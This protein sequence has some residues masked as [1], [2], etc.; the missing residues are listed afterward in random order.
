MEKIIE[1]F[2]PLVPNIEGIFDEILGL[3]AFD[4]IAIREAGGVDKAFFAEKLRARWN[5]KIYL[6]IS[7]SDR[8]RTAIRSELLT[9]AALGFS[10]VLLT[11]G[12][13]PITT[14]FP[15]AKAV[16]DLDA[17]SVLHMLKHDSAAFMG[18]APPVHEF[19][20]W[21]AGF[22]IGG[23][24][25]PDMMRAERSLAMGA[26]FLVAR[27]RKA[28]EL[29]RPITTRPVILSICRPPASDISGAL[30]EARA[31]GADGI[32][33]ANESTGRN[34]WSRTS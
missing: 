32:Y 8:N 5:R 2:T 11:D 34:E 9:A 15:S 31:A 30:E 3:D 21:K 33:M 29:L 6:T 4:S 1:L 16:Y 23:A 13:H 25:K 12:P 7:C 28:A 26:D 27:T 17:L 24:T 19:T 10:H 22:F 18:A 20:R 14:D